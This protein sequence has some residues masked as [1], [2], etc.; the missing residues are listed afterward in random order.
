MPCST[1][2]LIADLEADE[3]GND[4]CVTLPGT[5]TSDCPTQHIALQAGLT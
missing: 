3:G 1:R 4:V 5:I 2:Q